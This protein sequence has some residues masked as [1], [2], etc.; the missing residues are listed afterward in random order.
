MISEILQEINKENGTNYKIDILKKHKDNELFKR[1]LKMTYDKVAYTYGATSRNILK[2]VSI[3]ETEKYTLDEALD[4]LEVNICTRKITGHYALDACLLVYESLNKEDADVFMKIIDRDLKINV[5]KKTINKIFKDL[6]TKPVYMRCDV[7]ST[8]TSKNISFVDGAYIQLKADGTYR[9]IT[10]DGENLSSR[11]RSGED[12][13]LPVIFDQM[14]DFPDGV[15]MG[16]LT[17]KGITD[18]AEGNGLINSD[19]P[20]HNDIMLDLWD[21]VTHDEYQQARTNAK[22]NP[23]TTSYFQR[24]ET[25]YKIINQREVALDNIR[26]IQYEVVYSLKDALTKTSEWMDAGFEGGVLKDFKG[27]FKDGTSKHQ[28]K[29][30]LEIS[31]EMRITGFQDG[32]PGTKRE[33]KVG[34]IIFENDEGTIKGRT[35]G[36]DDN[37]LEY[38]TNNKDSLIGRIIEVQFNDLSKGRDNDHYALSHPRFIEIR[39]DKDE[40]DTLDKVKKLREMALGLK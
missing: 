20:P 26:V 2:R 4:F 13:D 17:I 9:E 25:L 24:F 14:R 38:F 37:L 6:I 19:N 15:Y 36:F 10:K 7:Y 39:D 12:Y 27:V 35:S 23:C 3:L 1:V 30:K 18:R 31:A 8:K 21:Y 28:L 33:G 5:G 16:E 32:T 29:L 40:T 11:S 22:D 34:S